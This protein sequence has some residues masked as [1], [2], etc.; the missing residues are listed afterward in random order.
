MELEST[1]LETENKECYSCGSF[2]YEDNRQEEL[3][4][5][6]QKH[7]KNDD[8]DFL[9]SIPYQSNFYRGICNNAKKS[10]KSRMS[11]NVLNEAIR[12]GYSFDNTYDSYNY[13]IVVFTASYEKLTNEINK[14]LNEINQSEKNTKLKKMERD[15]IKNQLKILEKDYIEKCKSLTDKLREINE[16]LG[17]NNNSSDDD[18]DDDAKNT[19]KNLPSGW[20]P[21]TDKEKAV[22]KI[23]G[24][25]YRC[26]NPQN[27]YNHM[28]KKHSKQSSKKN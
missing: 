9:A 21:S 7:H 14:S 1:N 17:L 13:A 8:A 22:C 23:C 16:E 2:T 20:K 28:R 3:R 4:N 26:V 12:K 15:G 25:I 24:G 11:D 27:L 10:L 6:K 19:N 5:N 18:D